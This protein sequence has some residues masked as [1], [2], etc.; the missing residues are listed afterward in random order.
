MN[1]ATCAVDLAYDRAKVAR[2]RLSAIS[3]VET[4]ELVWVGVTPDGL[5]DKLAF[6]KKY[7]ST[8]N[9]TSEAS[10]AA[11]FVD[12]PKGDSRAISGIWYGAEVWHEWGRF[13]DNK[14][15]TL[16]IHQ[17]LRKGEHYVAYETVEEDALI[18]VERQTYY[19]MTTR[20]AKPAYAAGTIYRLSEVA[21]SEDRGTWSCVLEK[22]T[23]NNTSITAPAAVTDAGNMD[24]SPRVTSLTALFRGATAAP[25]PLGAGVYG[26][27]SYEKNRF[28]RYDGQRTI[29]S[30]NETVTIAGW[31]LGST[32]YDLE[33]VQRV[34]RGTQ[35][36]QRTLTF[37]VNVIQTN[38]KAAAYSH[39]DGGLTGTEAGSSR[40][41]PL[42]NFQYRAI[43]ITLK[44]GTGTPT[45]WTADGAVLPE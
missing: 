11:T 24:V 43:K 20:P 15:L 12:S 45:S 40:V 39:I 32:T 35:F 6:L 42:A 5:N 14:E 16:N 26:R 36:Y 27:V 44:S 3:G 29:D 1:E 30:Y 10:A 25:S 37:T 7:T 41:E 4:L 2:R 9:W 31:A 22:L 19:A 21:F 28:G 18:K 33:H 17:A 13:R 38:S 34:L 23:Q 8:K